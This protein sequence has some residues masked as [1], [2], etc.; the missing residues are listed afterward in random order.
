M[1]SPAFS[2]TTSSP[3]RMSLRAISSKLCSV[4]FWMVVPASFTGASRATGVS[5][6]LLPTCTSIRSSFVTA[7]S[8]WNLNATIPRGA[9]LVAPRR[10]CWSSEFTLITMPSS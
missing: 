5:T 7:S 4:A 2:M 6:P 1:I 8:G 3:T 9:L 10:R